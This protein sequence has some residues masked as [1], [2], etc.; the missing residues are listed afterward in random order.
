MMDRPEWVA[1][2]PETREVYLTLTNNSR[3]GNTP[4]SSNKI[5]GTT[6]AATANPAVDAA[7]PRPDNDFGHIIRWRDAMGS[8]GASSF[9]WDIFVK[10]GDKDTTKLLGGTYNPA[11][12]DGYVGNINGDDYGA[13]DGLWFDQDGRLWIQTDQA[14]DAKGDWVNIGGNVMMCA[15]PVT[16]ETRRFLTA[17]PH[18]EVTGVITTPDGSTMFV[19]IQHP[20]EDWSV[21]FT[22]NSQWPDNGANGDTTFAGT[23]PAKPRSSVI[24]ITKD[25]GGVIGT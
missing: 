15:D 4:V 11:G 6:T 16:G 21:S 13:P 7:N 19:G 1:V 10:C 2:H 3:R 5:D 22:V 25:D 23:T 17:P 24:V 18:S 12:H 14:G 20:G 8:V 9:E